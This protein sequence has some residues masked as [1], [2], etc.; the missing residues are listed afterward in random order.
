MENPCFP[1]GLTSN[2][3]R[4]DTRVRTGPSARVV[5]PKG[6]WHPSR[7]VAFYSH[8]PRQSD[9]PAENPELLTTGAWK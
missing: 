1:L 3:V 6:L 8:W 2:T 9:L 7:P 4:L 5:P